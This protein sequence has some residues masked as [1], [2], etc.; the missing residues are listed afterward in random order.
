MNCNICESS[1]VKNCF[2]NDD[3]I[4][5]SQCRNCGIYF[6]YP[7]PAEKKISEFYAG[8]DYF[9]HWFEYK[10]VK[11]KTDKARIEKIL[12]EKICVLPSNPKLF[13]Y[14]CGPGFFLDICKK[15]GFDT[16]GVEYSDFAVDYCIKEM[17]L[18]VFKFA[19]LPFN[20]PDGSFDIITIWHT[21]EHLEK[22]K[23]TLLEFKRMLKPG[24]ALVI[25]IP[26]TNGLL[27][28][29]RGKS[30]YPLIEH[31]FHFN[32]NSLKF[33]IKATGFEL[34]KLSPGKPGYTRTG[35]KIIIKKLLAA[36]GEVIYSISG[37]N[38]GDTLL[39]YC[40]KNI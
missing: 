14:G 37:I 12:K 20:Y 26:N 27:S 24:G 13:D 3:E 1:D 17:K 9:K 21:L 30:A 33:L 35:V 15:K 31:L 38:C 23:E 11:L 36:A 19:G 40:R 32:P 28:I 25:E 29:I 18:N 2:V 6:T 8:K 5:L 7:K 16:F 39:A 4:G 10:D 34:I 22:P